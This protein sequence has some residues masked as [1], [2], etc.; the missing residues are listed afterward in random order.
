MKFKWS[1]NLFQCLLSR[2]YWWKNTLSLS[3]V[4]MFWDWN[5]HQRSPLEV[6]RWHYSSFFVDNIKHGFVVCLLHIPPL[7]NCLKGKQHKWSSLLKESHN[8]HFKLK[9][10]TFFLRIVFSRKIAVYYKILSEAAIRKFGKVLSNVRS[11]TSALIL[12]KTLIEG[13][14]LE[15]S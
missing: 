9:A 12:K 14:F 4:L 2:N 10:H 13:I 11:W 1:P 5:F 7:T 15:F 3:K 6:W 8:N